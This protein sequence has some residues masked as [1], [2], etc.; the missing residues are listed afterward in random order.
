L[1]SVIS[2]PSG[3]ES[4][5]SL[6]N[7]REKLMTTQTGLFG[8]LQDTVPAMPEGFRYEEDIITEVEEAFLVAS[9]AT[10]E[11]KPFE[12]HG[13][14][15]NR[16]VTAFGLRYDYARR[17]VEA[18]DEFPP[19]LIKLR[20]KVAAFAGREVHEFQQ[21]GI[22]QY[23]PGAGIGWHKDKPQFGTI[24]GI[25]LLA[26]ATMRLR[27]SSGTNWIRKS[28]ELTPRSIYI[29]EGEARTRWEHSIPPVHSLRYSLTF[30]TL[31]GG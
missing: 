23:P 17:T 11:L 16:R 18:A 13:H 7:Y 27:L 19:F 6:H 12:F 24:V 4:A 25:S 10:L 20:N 26:S 31:A 30:R 28:Q 21:G 8:D 3:G 9:L 1:R 29:L 22:N 15:G 14:V 2:I 5:I